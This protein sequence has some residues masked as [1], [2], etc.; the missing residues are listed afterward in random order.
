MKIKINNSL[1]GD[2]RKEMGLKLI[3]VEMKGDIVVF[4][5]SVS[6]IKV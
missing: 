4:P 6:C 3:Q 2:M 5:F 1:S